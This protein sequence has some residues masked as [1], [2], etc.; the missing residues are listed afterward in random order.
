ME[1][2]MTNIT[3]DRSWGGGDIESARVKFTR[4]LLVFARAR[5]FARI[6]GAR[7]RLIQSEM[8]DPR[9]YADIGLDFE[10]HSRR[11]WIVEMVRAMGV[12]L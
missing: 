12:R 3:L 5:R 6:R 2:A 4:H 11:D 10:K 8:R 1:A 9:W 7:M